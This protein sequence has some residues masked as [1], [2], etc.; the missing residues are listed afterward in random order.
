MFR[1]D[2]INKRRMIRDGERA[3]VKLSKEAKEYSREDMAAYH[4]VQEDF[5]MEIELER[6]MVDHLR[7]LIF[8]ENNSRLPVSVPE[9]TEEHG[10]WEKGRWTGRWF[11]T[12][13]GYEFLE[14][15]YHLAKQRHFEMV[16]R[17][18]GPTTAILGALSGV[19]GVV[20][21][22]ITIWPSQ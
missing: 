14:E 16:T 11:L 10:L 7:T 5:R 21:A 1:S 6:E 15:K 2:K 9:R 4:E 3:I 13:A 12:D 17:W 18:I 8:L 22:L 20:I 19:G